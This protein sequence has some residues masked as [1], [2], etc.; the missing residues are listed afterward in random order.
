MQLHS[1]TGEGEHLISW[2]SS[3]SYSSIFFVIASHFLQGWAGVLQIP[4]QHQAMPLCVGVFTKNSSLA[5]IGMGLLCVWS[6]STE[7]GFFCSV[8]NVLSLVWSKKKGQ[9]SLIWLNNFK[10]NF[11]FITIVPRSAYK[12]K[13][14]Y[15][16]EKISCVCCGSCLTGQWV[17]Q[18]WLKTHLKSVE[19]PSVIT[20][21]S[22]W[23]LLL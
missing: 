22:E 13:K 5:V 19:V 7:K 14:L 16:D 20:H 18:E 21:P 15:I 17:L 3:Q 2:V 4:T 9:A 1:Q 6:K 23:N 11:F 8:E 10:N 12:E